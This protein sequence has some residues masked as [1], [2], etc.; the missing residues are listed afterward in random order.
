MLLGYNL[1]YKRKIGFT[2]GAVFQKLLNSKIGSTKTLWLL[3]EQFIEIDYESKEEENLEKS[4]IQLASKK[5]IKDKPFIIA[6]KPKDKI[7]LEGTSFMI[8]TP[9]EAID[10]F[11]DENF[12]K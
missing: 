7:N 1:E 8:L 4:I 2:S 9:K 11:K 12:L 6:T 3:P 5:C 10:M